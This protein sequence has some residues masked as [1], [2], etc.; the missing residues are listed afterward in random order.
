MTRAMRA[1]AR[2]LGAGLA[3]LAGSA[4]GGGPATARPAALPAELAGRYGQ[5]GAIGYLELSADGAFEAFVVN[6]VTLDGCGTFEGAG[7]ARGR[8]RVEDGLVRFATSPPRPDLVVD[9]E[10]VVGRPSPGGLLLHVEGGG[11]ALAA[12]QAPEPPRA[13]EGR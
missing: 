4:C 10:Q 6:G 1:S 2:S 7:L 8:W 9:L 5:A 13:S 11:S 12:R 3:L